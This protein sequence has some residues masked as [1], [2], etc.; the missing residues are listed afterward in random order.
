M[1]SGHVWV[2]KKTQ[3]TNSNLKISGNLTLDP[4]SMHHQVEVGLD[5]GR[6]VSGS[7]TRLMGWSDNLTYL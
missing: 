1:V 5:R 3:T 2:T 4:Y 7:V 6:V